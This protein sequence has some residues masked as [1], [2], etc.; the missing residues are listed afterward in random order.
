[1][2]A[3]P[4]KDLPVVVYLASLTRELRQLLAYL[5]FQ[6]PGLVRVRLSRGPLACLATR[7][8]VVAVSNKDPLRSSKHCFL[9]QAKRKNSSPIQRKP[10]AVSKGLFHRL[11]L[12]HTR[13]SSRKEIVTLKVSS[14]TRAQYTLHFADLRHAQCRSLGLHVMT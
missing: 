14:F 2:N 13:C 3:H 7:N 6:K 9:N 10:V 11:Q 12:L 8:N 4:C 1:M 5:T